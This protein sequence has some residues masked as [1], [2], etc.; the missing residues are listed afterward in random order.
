MA[1]IVTSLTTNDSYSN[2]RSLNNQLMLV[3][4][5]TRLPA[6]VAGCNQNNTLLFPGHNNYFTSITVI[7]SDRYKYKHGYKKKKKNNKIS[8]VVHC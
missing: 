1:N 6:L 5:A 8:W 3:L 7:T 2:L 4:L